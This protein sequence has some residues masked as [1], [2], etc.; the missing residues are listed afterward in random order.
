MT[1]TW[2]RILEN[3]GDRIGGPISFRFIL[4]PIVAAI[5]AIVSGWQDAK[6][7]RSPYLWAILTQPTMS[8]S[9]G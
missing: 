2:L 7:G 6:H 5:L 1:E 3:L 9:R 4:Q 8:I